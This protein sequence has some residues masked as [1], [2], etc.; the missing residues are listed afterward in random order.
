MVILIRP[1]C[2]VWTCRFRFKDYA[3]SW[4]RLQLQAFDCK[5]GVDIRPELHCLWTNGERRPG[6]SLA[7]GLFVSDVDSH[8]IWIS[9]NERAWLFC[10]DMR[11]IITNFISIAQLGQTFLA[12][13]GLSVGKTTQLGFTI[14]GVFCS[15]AGF[16]RLGWD[17]SSLLERISIIPSCVGRMYF[18]LWSWLDY[19][20]FESGVEFGGCQAIDV[21]TS[22]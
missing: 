18:F 11:S 21:G 16:T 12:G 22:K 15:G 20:E 5:I 19:I 10:R 14:R 3:F 9:E 4:S 13:V 17:S 1:S 2:V 7:G 6:H 8:R